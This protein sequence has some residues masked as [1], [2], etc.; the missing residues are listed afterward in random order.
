[1]LDIR[2]LRYFVA[3]VE[4]GS[5]SRAANFLHVAQP[6]LSLHVRNMEADMGTPL[7]I[8]VP[9]GV[10]PTEAGTILMRHARIILDQLTVAE[11]EIRGHDNDPSGEVRLGLPGTIGQIVA[12]P[13]ITAALTRYPRIR[14]RIAEAMSGFVLEW[15]RDERIEL[16]VLYG[17]ADKHGISTQRLLDEDLLF[18]GPAEG[19]RDEDMPPSGT[20]LSFGTIARMPLI[21][22]AQGH[23][24]RDLLTR[25]GEAAGTGMN[26]VID[27]DSYGNIKS[28]VG[29]GFGYSI[30][31]ENAI[32]A[33]VREGRLR[34]WMIEN[35]RL[36]RS[37][38]LAR[39]G[40]RQ[41]TKAAAAVQDLTRET[42]MDLARSGQWIGARI[43]Q[44]DGSPRERD[45]S[46]LG[47]HDAGH[48]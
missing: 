44:E 43:S 8:R 6:A 47:D 33:E 26:T 28:L 27:V 12:V 39:S 15:L 41:M 2:Q 35:P 32:G 36:T 23:G 13:L 30:L 31:P 40:R 3:I 11:E 48:N 16:A 17:Q 25:T 7:L 24:L 4:H 9:R 1:M 21:L 10:E 20:A 19:L 34:S 5:F 14:L 45:A 37:I 46:V 29:E 42:L 22:P 38:H 18:F